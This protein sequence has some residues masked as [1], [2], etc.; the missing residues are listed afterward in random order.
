MWAQIFQSSGIPERIRSSSSPVQLVLVFAPRSVLL[1]G[2][3]VDRIR[4]TFASAIVC[5]CSTGG[6]ILDDELIDEDA[7]VM[8][9]G[10][11][12]SEVRLMS[13]SLSDADSSRICG[14]ALGTALFRSD[15]TGVL[16]LADGLCVNGNELVEGLVAAVGEG[17]VVAG[18]MAA[19]GDAFISTV[20]V[21]NEIVA[22]NLV[23]AIGV[24]GAAFRMRTGI[25]D[26][27]QVFGLRAGW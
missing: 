26:G 1:D 24:Y 7:V 23:V 18:G 2:R 17:V 15:L 22:S 11:E 9:L 21:A 27:G 16:V 3:S 19:D 12:H 6:Q 5:G 13:E 10:F 4:T 14:E 25:G 8:T 20:I